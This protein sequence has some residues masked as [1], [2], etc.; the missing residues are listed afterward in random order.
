MMRKL[1]Q[2]VKLIKCGDTLL[3]SFIFTLYS[4]R[5]LSVVSEDSSSADA[6]FAARQSRMPAFN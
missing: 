1:A 3:K 2:I 5:S 4:V 6:A